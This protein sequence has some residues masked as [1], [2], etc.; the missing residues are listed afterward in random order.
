MVDL[1]DGTPVIVDASSQT[2]FKITA[3]ALRAAITNKTK[4]FIFNS[5]SNPTGAVYHPDEIRELADVLVSTQRF[6]FFRRHL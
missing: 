2:G 6:L 4:L 5:P 3:E 1:A